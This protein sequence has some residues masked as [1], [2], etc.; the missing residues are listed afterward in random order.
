MSAEGVL[1]GLFP[2]TGNQI[3]NKVLNWQ[4]IPVHIESL[5]SPLRPDICDRFNYEMIKYI[6][7]TAYK[8][9]LDK[10]KSFIKILNEN[11]GGNFDTIRTIYRLYDILFIE[12]LKGKR[13]VNYF[14]D[15]DNYAN[16]CTTTHRFLVFHHGLKS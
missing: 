10:R 9:I 4:P 2:P 12:Q 13:Q 1:A 6:N 8:S 3:W 16:I 5:S 14:N 11:E 7:T 15:Y